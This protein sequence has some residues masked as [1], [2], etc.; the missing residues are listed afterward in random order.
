MYM[1]DKPGFDV[2]DCV[3]SLQQNNKIVP[4]WHNLSVARILYNSKYLSVC[5]FVRLSVCL[6][7][8]VWKNISFTAGI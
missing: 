5:S 7:E 8:T 6:L 4:Y 3:C 1:R 2:F